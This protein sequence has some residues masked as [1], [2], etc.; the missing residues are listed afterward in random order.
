[1]SAIIQNFDVVENAIKTSADSAGSALKE[2]EKYLNSIQGKLDLFNNAVQTMWTNTLNSDVVKWFVNLGTQAVKLVDTLGLIPSILAAIGAT[3]GIQF[4]L[5]SLKD[6]G[7]TIK[8]VLSYINLLTVGFKQNAVAQTA[9]NA[10]TMAH[11]V[12]N[13]LFRNGLIQ[14]LATQYLATKSTQALELA[15]YN[16]KLAEMGLLNGIATVK[17]VQ[18]AQAAVEAASIPVDI[19]KIGTTELMGL[20]FKQLALS[21]WSAVKAIGAFLLTN[22]VG[23]I[24]LAVGAIVGGIAAWNKWGDTTENLTKRLNDLKSELQD[25]Q[26]EL[27]SVNSE[28]ETTNNRMAELLAKDSLTFTEK[29]E[30][31]NLRKQNDELQRRID[32]LDSERKLKQSEAAKDFT[33]LMDKSINQDTYNRAGKRGF[34]DR[35]FDAWDTE[36]KSEIWSADK[37]FDYL[38]EEYEKELQ[39]QQDQEGREINRWTETK[40]NPEKYSEKIREQLKAWTDAADGLDYGI[41]K[42]TDEWLDYVYN[43]QDK[44]AIA[45]GGNNAKTNAIN[46]IFNKDE[47]AEISDSID[48]YV[49]ALRNGDTNAKSSIENIIKNNKALVEDLEASGL[50]VD[51]AVDYFTSFA[52]D[53]EFAT[54]EGKIEEVSKAAT[55]F[56]K[57]LK[58]GLFKVDG[59]DTGLADLFDEEGKIIQTKLSQVFQSTSDQTRKE[60]TRLLESSYD[61]I[62]DGLDD[63]EINYLMN[64][65]GLS[66]SRAILEI[67]K[68][69]LTNKNLELFPGL[70]DEISGIIDTFSELTSAIGSVVD[71]MD[72]LDKARAEE[73]YSGSVS[74]ETLEALMQSTDNYA[75]LI[76]V[77]E[78]GAI[79]LAT[80]AQEILVAQK[81]EAIK[82]NAALALKEAELAYQE[83]LHTE[84][85]YSQTGPAQDFMR[86]LWNEV[87]GAMAFVS[88]LWRD[89]TSGNWSGAWDRAQAAKEKS[90]TQKETDYANKAAIASAAV[91]EAAKNVENAEKMNDIAQGLTPDNIKIK[92]S[93]DEASGGAD[94]EEDVVKNK[95]DELLAKFERELVLITNER[96]LIESQISQLEATGSKASSQYYKDL[97]RNSSEEKQLLIDKKKELEDYLEANKDNVDKETWS[98]MNDEINATAVAIKECTTNLLEYYN[99]LEEIDSHYFEQAMDEV[100]RLGEEIQ[101][102]QGLLEDEK[103]VEDDGTFTEAGITTLGLYISEMERAAKS[104]EQYQK[105][106]NDIANSWADYQ[107]LLK[108]AKDV[109]GDGVITVEDIDTKELDKLYDTYG[110]IITSE[111]EFKEKTDQVTDSMRDQVEAQQAARKALIDLAQARIDAIKDGIDKE[112]EAYEDLIDLKK[113]ELDAERDLF[114]FR[115]NVQKQTK[116][117][118]SLERRIASLSGSDNAAD[119]AERKRLEAQLY[120]QKESLSDTYY[121]HAKDQ[122]SQALDDEVEAFRD[123]KERYMEQLDEW[124]EDTEAVVNHMILEGL[125]N[126]DVIS[127]FLSNVETQYGAPLSNDLKQPFINASEQARVWKEQVGAYTNECVPFVVSLSE[128]IKEKLGENGAWS[129]AELAAKDYV[130]FITSKDLQNNLDKNISAFCTSI[131]GI[132]SKWED[133]KKKAD[134]AYTAQYRAANVGGKQQDEIPPKAPE[135]DSEPNSK[136]DLK[137]TKSMHKTGTLGQQIT[138]GDKA[139]LDS[140]TVSIDGKKYYKRTVTDKNGKST[141]YYYD[142]DEAKQVRYDGGRSKG[143]AFIKGASVYQYYAKGTT[144]TKKDQWAIT[145][146]PQFGDELTMYATPEGTLSYMRAGS[147]VTPAALTKEIIDIANVGLDGLMNAN[148]FGTNINMISN[149]I[150]KPELN[151]NVE[152][153]LSIDKVDEGCLPEVKKFV[154]QE[155]DSFVRKLNY[156]LKGIGAR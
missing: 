151:F 90:V 128:T 19:S 85:T 97:I 94:T 36:H 144:G 64:R 30:L 79:R 82:Q 52:S 42:E 21:I 72:T 27:D 24:I 129:K 113:E 102:V 35:L 127:E 142:I 116:D 2:N 152:K 141:Y 118:A 104:Q 138:V 73:A 149:A 83:A 74:L 86:G 84:Q 63:S 3:K 88:S 122:Q 38:I 109:N 101:F 50:S 99:T 139:Y 22:P 155:L 87:G 130:D 20:A 4:L 154:Q 66:F 93:S 7:V 68:N 17:D 29:E 1:M 131:G 117:I 76:E 136:P 112:I 5:K 143:Y 23:W 47:N 153:F 146:E 124:M 55:N 44:W 115:K 57:L 125:F 56:E 111:E 16:L 65:M 80:N 61:M 10:T 96:D 123:A 103:L 53:L 148:K 31:E 114:E 105:K 134:E 132:V 100:S 54:L 49:E 62:A 58:G 92:Y 51:E 59:V 13:K 137:P 26:S 33:T 147:T 46:R 77:D 135:P 133:V 120:E 89:L 95:W 14:T 6:S 18:A 41:N 8:S 37:Y 70:K 110:I 75:D 43:L 28:L 156:S 126:A 107:E 145:D 12:A 119:I 15:K 91:A 9:A 98:E 34:W 81:I 71:A 150:N 106:I 69:N 11:D 121:D 108:N 67:E 32:L 78:T 45:S 60:I 140:K 25:I 39:K 48:E 40:A